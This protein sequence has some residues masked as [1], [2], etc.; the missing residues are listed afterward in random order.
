MYW[1]HFA[2]APAWL[3]PTIRLHLPCPLLSSGALLAVSPSPLP[4]SWLLIH[5]C[6]T[7]AV[8]VISSWKRM[9]QPLSA[10][11]TCYKM[12]NLLKSCW[13]FPP[14]PWKFLRNFKH[15][16]FFTEEAACS[17][18][19]SIMRIS[20]PLPACVQRSIPAHYHSSILHKPVSAPF[21]GFILSIACVLLEWPSFCSFPWTVQLLLFFDSFL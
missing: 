9:W 2:S 17:T 10:V 21:P 8:V 4:F 15:S 20:T 18:E 3:P 7:N 11:D 6:S 1:S 12:L 14:I 16:C 19:T 13:E 5:E